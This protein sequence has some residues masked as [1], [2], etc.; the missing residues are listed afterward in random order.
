M[1]PQCRIRIEA[2]EGPLDLLLHLIQKNRIEISDI[3][4][5]LITSQYLNYLE[6]MKALDIAVAGE[7][8]AM[9]ATLL[10]IKSA[11]LLPK[12]EP[13]DP[14]DDPR[15]EI[16]RPLQELVKIR[17]TARELAEYPLLGREIFLPDVA[18]PFLS[19]QTQGD[20]LPE[21]IPVCADLIGLI[22]ALKTVISAKDLAQ[23][24]KI[25]KARIS[26]AE[27]IDA[28]GRELSLAGRISLFEFM[29]WEDLEAVIVTFLALL[30]MVKQGMARVHQ[31]EAGGDI[32]VFSPANHPISGQEIP[33]GQAS[34]ASTEN[35]P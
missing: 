6:F 31:D 10:H 5:A 9:A 13:L 8:L 35:L 15:L 24:I 20:D 17:Q 1:E 32:F 3:P 23:T 28:I 25:A 30:E 2:F 26:M 19:G 29:P 4:I 7:Y 27:R 12:P 16:V 14:E 34:S 33:N 22:D 21:D 18:A 11:T